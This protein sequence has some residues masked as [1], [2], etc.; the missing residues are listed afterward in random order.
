MATKTATAV[1]KVRELTEEEILKAPEKDYMNEAQLAFFRKK[2]LELRDQLLQ[3]ADDTGEHLRENEITTDP[4]D[5]ATLEEEYTLELRTRDRERKLLKKVEK[6]LRM[7][8]DGSYGWC[9]ETGEPIGVPRLIARP[10]ATLSLEA[11]ERRERV[12]KLYGD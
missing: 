9:E 1:K 11:Q 7:I 10:T 4:S 3:N 2:L 12:Q 8:D 5:R 6:S